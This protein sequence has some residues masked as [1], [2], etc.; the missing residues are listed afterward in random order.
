MVQKYQYLG[1]NIQ[2]FEIDGERERGREG[3]RERG[4]EGV[5]EGGRERGRE[6]GREGGRERGREGRREGGYIIIMYL[7][8]SDSLGVPGGNCNAEIE[9]SLKRQSP[10]WLCLLL[11]G[12]VTL[13]KVTWKLKQV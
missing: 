9:G 12:T 7:H 6:G 13:H 4:R 3:E 10:P 8:A 2:N 1:I 11:Q 5:R